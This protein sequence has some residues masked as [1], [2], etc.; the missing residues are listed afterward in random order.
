MATPAVVGVLKLGNNGTVVDTHG[1]S[2]A[3]DTVEANRTGLPFTERLPG[4]PTVCR[5]SLE[6]HLFA[7]SFLHELQL[8]CP[9]PRTGVVGRRAANGRLKS[10]GTQGGSR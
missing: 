5:M 2:P 3:A 9:S 7:L 8:T 1:R 4:G 6:N 10:G